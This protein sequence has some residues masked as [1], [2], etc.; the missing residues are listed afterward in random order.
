MFEFISMNTHIKLT[1]P[2]SLTGDSDRYSKPLKEVPYC[3]LKS[4][5]HP[6]QIQNFLFGIEQYFENKKL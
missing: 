5:K 4:R 6:F 2:I 1:R 3:F